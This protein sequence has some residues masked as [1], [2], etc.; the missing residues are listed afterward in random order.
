[1]ALD[2]IS[3][4]NLDLKR[5]NTETV[6]AV[7]YDTAGRIKAQLTNDGEA[8]HVPSSAGGM[9]S[10]RKSDNIGGFYDTTEL[11]EVAVSVDENDDSIIY[12]ALDAQTTITATPLDHPVQMQI[13]FYNSQ[14]KRLS[15][16]AFYLRVQ[17]SVLFEGDQ[18]ERP[19]AS[20]WTFRILTGALGQ[21]IKNQEEAI[22]WMED[23][24]RTQA[25]YV[26][27]DT[28]KVEGA[29]GDAK[30]IGELFEEIVKISDSMPGY[31][32]TTDTA[33]VGNTKYYTRSGTSPNYVYTEYTGATFA[34]GVTYY[35]YSPWNRIW[36]DPDDNDIEIPTMD[37]FDEVKSAMGL[38]DPSCTLPSGYQSISYENSSHTVV[39]KYIDGRLLINKVLSAGSIS[40]DNLRITDSH[41]NIQPGAS[42]SYNLTNQTNVWLRYIT[43]V[44]ANAGNYYIELRFYKSDYSKFVTDSNGIGK[45]FDPRNNV[46]SDLNIL[47]YASDNDIDISTYP[48]CVIMG[49]RWTA[50]IA[51]SNESPCLEIEGFYAKTWESIVDRV[52]TLETEKIPLSKLDDDVVEYLTFTDCKDIPYSNDG[53]YITITDDSGRFVPGSLV[54]SSGFKTTELIPI[55]NVSEFALKFW[56]GGDKVA[57]IG[58][59]DAS[60]DWISGVS[61]PLISSGINNVTIVATDYPPGTAFIRFCTR[62]VEGGYSATRNMGIVTLHSVFGDV[63]DIDTSIDIL[64]DRISDVEDTLTP[65]TYWAVCGDSITNANHESIYEIPESDP[66]YPIDGYA[67]ISYARKNYAYYFAREHGISWANYGYGGTTL[68]HCAPKGYPNA[69]P[70]PFVDSRIENF[71]DGVDWTYITIFFGWNDCTYG[72]A[73][74]RD[75]WLQETYGTDIGYPVT[76]EQI[77]ASGFA[78]QAQKDACDAVTGTV[79]GVEYDNNDDYFFAKF[80]GTI[81]DTV[82]TTWMGAWNYALDYLMRKY[83]D[84]KIMIVVPYIG[85]RSA[86]VRNAVKQI[87]AKWGVVCFDFEDLPYWFYKITPNTTPFAPTSGQWTTGK[88]YECPNTVEGY[89]RA[90][91]TWDNLHLSNLGYKTL[92]DPFGS[93]L[94]NS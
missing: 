11:G 57:N 20:E 14:G 18:D 31:F 84:A 12:I 60:G 3:T 47:Q 19:V 25:G 92:A 43:S 61:Y 22:K 80:I 56:G 67:G 79:G 26:V 85:N 64:D 89:N 62:A 83:P 15:T 77:G 55:E 41:V 1:M 81:N 52:E 33:R 73:Y 78:T 53:K 24:I 32:P 23:N 37:E 28:L 10:F 72:P 75:L 65:H 87:A 16:F 58:Y 40:N 93:K 82:K 44:E 51:A 94:L 8:W 91:L 76:S 36:I 68:H 54:L 45:A 30:K 38:Q 29:A 5:P 50:H 21:T 49:L 66:Y 59:Y 34:T 63:E 46:V 4:I 27:D 13:N 2:I 86:M 88:G 35:E 90:R 74:Q 69:Y 48:N 71:K 7:Q 17:A 6:Y 70:N 42:V 9:V 39:F